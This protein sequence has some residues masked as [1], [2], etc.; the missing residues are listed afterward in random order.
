MMGETKP[1]MSPIGEAGAKLRLPK[2][3]NEDPNDEHDPVP[4]PDGQDAQ[5]H[6][7]DEV[8]DTETDP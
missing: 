4:L 7:Q 5:G 8:E 1:I 3:G 2:Q 6:E